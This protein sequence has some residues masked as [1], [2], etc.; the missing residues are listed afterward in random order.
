MPFSL[1]SMS[2]GL[3][4]LLLKLNGLLVGSE[5]KLTALGQIVRQR[6]GVIHVTNCCNNSLG[7]RNT[8][9]EKIHRKRK[10]L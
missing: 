6:V 7:S 4:S 8:N 3:C 10:R 1:R 2:L 9:L 5:Q